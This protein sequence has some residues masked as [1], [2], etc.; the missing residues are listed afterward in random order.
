M[1]ETGEKVKV[2][3]TSF[4]SFLGIAGKI[5]KIKER[6]LVSSKSNTKQYAVDV[7]GETWWL[8]EDEIE[9]VPN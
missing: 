2:K 6:L 9:E 3:D 4:N 5:G 1:L 8:Y 7:D